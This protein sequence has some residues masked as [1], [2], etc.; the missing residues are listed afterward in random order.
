MIGEPLFDSR[1]IADRVGV[2]GAA[3]SQDYAGK[4]PLMIGLL[5]AAATFLADLIRAVTVP[6]HVDFISV[7][8]YGDGEGVAFEKDVGLQ[9]KTR[10]VQDKVRQLALSVAMQQGETFVRD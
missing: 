9:A 6:C 7:N 10:V 2:I 8:R 4:T 1:S 3:I 5:S